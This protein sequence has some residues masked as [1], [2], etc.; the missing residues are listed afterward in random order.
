[1][2]T[3][4]DLID[5][6][7]AGAAQRLAIGT[8]GQLLEVVGGAPAW[9]T[10]TYAPGAVVSSFI[11]STVSPAA[12]TPTNIT[13][14]SLVAGTWLIVGV[15][16]AVDSSGSAATTD[17]WLGPTTASATSAYTACSSGAGPVAG[18][19]IRDISPMAC[20]VVLAGT[21]TVYMGIQT[22]TST[23]VVQAASALL[24]VPNTTGIIAVR[25]A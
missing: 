22:Q 20:S 24:S 5:G 8:V 9:S 1:M 15:V 3:A 19:Q 2:T 4:G 23:L 17:T 11:S 25:T 7:A 6:G 13:S 16:N 14:V 21:T 10:L 12:N 18:V